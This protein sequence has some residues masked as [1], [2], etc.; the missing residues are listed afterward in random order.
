MQYIEPSNFKEAFKLYF[1]IQPFYLIAPSL[2]K[3]SVGFFL[4]RIAAAPVYKRIIIGIMTFMCLYTV[5]SFLTLMLQCTN[6]A[7]L[8]DPTATGTCWDPSI[9]SILNYVHVA[10]NITTDL[11]FSFVIPVS[12]LWGLQMNNRQKSSLMCILGLGLL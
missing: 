10:L 11:L 4:L 12:L 6:L 2:V 1:L 3:V 8:W 7:V 9:L 5:A